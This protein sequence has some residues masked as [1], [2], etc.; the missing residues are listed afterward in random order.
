LASVAGLESLPVLGVAFS[1]DEVAAVSNAAHGVLE[2]ATAVANKALFY[3]ANPF[4]LVSLASDYVPAECLNATKEIAQAARSILD[5]GQRV[6]DTVSAVAALPYTLTGAGSERLNA[7]VATLRQNLQYTR[8]TARLASY[9][10]D[11]VRRGLASTGQT[12]SRLSD[13]QASAGLCLEVSCQAGTML[14]ACRRLDQ[15]SSI[16]LEKFT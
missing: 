2:T 3:A 11:A 6:F 9:G 16:I 12:L 15:D 10:M 1:L 8:D 4:A 7:V 13:R 5:V 14:A